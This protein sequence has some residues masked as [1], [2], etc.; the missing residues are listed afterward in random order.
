MLLP[1]C[2]SVTEL[3]AILVRL[4]WHYRGVIHELDGVIVARA[5]AADQRR[6]KIWRLPREST[7]D[8]QNGR[9]NDQTKGDQGSPMIGAGPKG[10]PQSRGRS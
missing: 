9:D 10:F 2:H 6:S 8:F 1:C 3:Q 5:A 7:N 4:R